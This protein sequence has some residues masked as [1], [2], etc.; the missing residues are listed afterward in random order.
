MPAISTACEPGSTCSRSGSSN[1][2][3][4][5]S[6]RVREKYTFWNAICLSCLRQMRWSSGVMS[7]GHFVTM[8]WC[9]A[10]SRDGISRN[11]PAGSILSLD[12]GR[13]ASTMM[14]LT[15]AATLRC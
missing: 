8:K 14:T 10:R 15:L 2:G 4:I 12:T 13:V 9:A 6:G 7:S 3:L 1:S 5:G 11:D